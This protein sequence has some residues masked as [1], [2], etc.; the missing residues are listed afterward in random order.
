MRSWIKIAALGIIL[1]GTACERTGRQDQ[2]GIVDPGQPA[3]TN[4]PD[5][6]GQARERESPRVPEDT[7]FNPARR[8]DE[9][10]EQL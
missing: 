8:A 5:T 1:A 9:R 10:N 4:I 2:P 3:T 6:T 7:S